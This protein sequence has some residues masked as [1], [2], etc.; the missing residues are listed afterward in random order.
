V[1]AFEVDPKSVA[2]SLSY[3]E[4]VKQN[5]L[6]AVRAGM[7][8]GMDVL[9]ENT[10]DAMHSAGIE[11]R[12][13]DLEERVLKSPRVTEDEAFIRGRV[14]AHSL[15]KARGGKEYINNLGNILNMGFREKAVKK[16]PMHEITAADGDTYWARG[17]RAFDVKPHPFFRR[18][19]EV[20]EAPIMDLI[21]NR[22]ADAVK[23]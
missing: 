23:A 22:V 6:E 10:V 8:E 19:V 16:V 18:A 3:I 20:S 9:A 21:R 5:I 2:S 13:G 11:K 15:V 4:S 17:H 12:S 14:S 7:A 1:I